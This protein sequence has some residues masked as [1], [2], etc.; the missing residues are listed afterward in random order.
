MRPPPWMHTAAWLLGSLGAGGLLGAL[1]LAG[2]GQT[3]AAVL[4]GL[5]SLLVASQGWRIGR[6]SK[7]IDDAD[8]PP[9][10]PRE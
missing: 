6:W 4:L 1:Y 7:R 2:G 8:R 10:S 5:T 3:G 9:E